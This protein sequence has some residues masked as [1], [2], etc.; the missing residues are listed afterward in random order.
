MIAWLRRFRKPKPPKIR[1][2]EEVIVMYGDTPMAHMVLV[3]VS[4]QFGGA[5]TG[6][7]IDVATHRAR[8]EK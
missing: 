1:F 4:S 6:S 5:T 8:V 3:E 7:L 2:G